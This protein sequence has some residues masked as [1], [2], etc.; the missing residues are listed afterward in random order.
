MLLLCRCTRL[1][2]RATDNGAVDTAAAVA[3]LEYDGDDVD[4]I[5]DDCCCCLLECMSRAVVVVVV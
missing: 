5:D 2:D 3:A 1:R 4:R